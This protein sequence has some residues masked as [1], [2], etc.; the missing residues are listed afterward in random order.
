M[1]KL[2]SLMLALMMLAIPMLGTAET[3]FGAMYEPY[4]DMNLAEFGILTDVPVNSYQLY[5][6]ALEAGRE[7]QST[8]TISPIAEGLIGDEKT[9]KAVND[10]LQALEI[11]SS[12]QGNEANAV[13]TLS[14]KD[15]LTLGFGQ[16]GTD[17]YLSSNLL[18]GTVVIGEGELVPVIERLVDMFVLMGAIPE[19]EAEEIKASLPEMLDMIAQELAGA[20]T[21]PDTSALANAD[22]TPLVDALVPIIARTEIKEVTEQ[23]T[24]CDAADSMAVVTIT[25]KDALDLVKG[26]LLTIKANPDLMDMLAQMMGYNDSF[27]TVYYEEYFGRPFSFEKDVI[28][29]GLASMEEA[30]ANIGEDSGEVELTMWFDGD[31]MVKLTACS[32][33]TEEAHREVIEY[34]RVTNANVITYTVKLID[35]YE[36]ITFVL[37]EEGPDADGV[38]TYTL[39]VDVEDEAA[40]FIVKNG[41]NLFSFYMGIPDYS[42]LME[43]TVTLTGDKVGDAYN[44][45]ADIQIKDESMNIGVVV[46]G[47]LTIDGVDF[48]ENA[49]VTLFVG[50]DEIV[51]MDAVTRTVKP[52]S[53]IMRA[54]AVR[55]ATLEDADFANWFVGVINEL[56][57]WAAELVQAVPASFIEMMNE[58]ASTEFVDDGTYYY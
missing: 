44:T 41:S 3:L 19:D 38:T 7:L 33:S 30:Y 10:L 37:T 36:P 52:T 46:D 25:E 55:P 34:T 11:K 50:G 51:S 29:E 27:Y 42:G 6:D 20:Y 2:L 4:L 5:Y 17:T 40:T 1:K 18:G 26:V 8:V 39:K 9:E 53:T 43:M 15:V 23:P 12:I 24:G 35:E 14:D 31:A 57:S 48:E 16:Q 54:D 32:H 58:P 21:M 22:V 56:G 45:K 28:D 49:K 13:I 47:V